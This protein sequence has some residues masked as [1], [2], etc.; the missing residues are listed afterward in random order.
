VFIH[1]RG[2]SFEG[3]PF[4]REQRL[5]AVVFPGG[6]QPPGAR[7]DD[8]LCQLLA[9]LLSERVL[10]ERPVE[11]L[12]ARGVDV[13]ALR[14]CLEAHC[15]GATDGALGGEQPFG[16]ALGAAAPAIPPSAS[17]LLASPDL[18]DALRRLIWE[19][20]AGDGG[21]FADLGS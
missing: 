20:T 4:E 10:S 6:D 13:A 2:S 16:P 17:A 9:C 19:L 7:P 14:A 21:G 11:E 1:A 15:R 5:T 8:R 12:E 3:Q 18:R